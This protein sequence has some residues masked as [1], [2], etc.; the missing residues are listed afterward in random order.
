MERNRAELLSAQPHLRTAFKAR[1]PVAVPGCRCSLP[2]RDLTMLHP[3]QQQG[4]GRPAWFCFPISRCYGD[5]EWWRCQGGIWVLAMFGMSCN[6]AGEQPRAIIHAR[7]RSTEGSTPS[8]CHCAPPSRP[9]PRRRASPGRGS[10]GSPGCSSVAVS[11]CSGEDAQHQ[12]VQNNVGFV[13]GHRAAVMKV[14]KLCGL[15]CLFASPPQQLQR[16]GC[17][18]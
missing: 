6:V 1:S 2:R 16:A 15:L 5:A 4:G 10:V 9:C 7:R 18:A 3:H 11:Q 14:A 13:R 12:L 17:P 8:Q